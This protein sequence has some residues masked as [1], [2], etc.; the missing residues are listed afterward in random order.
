MKI[1]VAAHAGYCYGVERALTMAREALET[2]SK[3]IH[4]LGP[5]IHNPQVVSRLAEE[6]IHEAARPDDITEGTAIIR[7][8]GVPPLVASELARRGIE[9]VDATCPF[10][11]KAQR[12]AAD[13]VRDGYQV[14]IVGEPEHPEVEGILGYAGDGNA[15]VVESAAD[16][17]KWRR[18]AKVGVVVQTTQQF[19]RLREVVDA[20]LPKANELKVCNTI[21]NATSERQRTAS[22]LAGKVD[23]MVVVGG[24]NSGN[25][26]RLVELCRARNPRTHHVETAADLHGAWF[27]DVGKVG[28]TAGASTPD[29][30]LGEVTARIE[31]LGRA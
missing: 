21:C 15:V 14:V 26:R 18:R 16:L 17:P 24:S 29:W 13:L 30:L 22:A 9:I 2:T 3:P 19:D 1:V 27:Q 23:V 6:G 25:T 8:H 11:G 28:V 31:E 20:L 10:V 5:I 7:S 4:S 12:C